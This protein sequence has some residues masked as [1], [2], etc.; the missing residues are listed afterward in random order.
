M[1]SDYLACEEGFTQTWDTVGAGVKFP[2]Q[3]ELRREERF[4]PAMKLSVS[5]AGNNAREKIRIF[6]SSFNETLAKAIHL[7]PRTKD[8]LGNTEHPRSRDSRRAA[9]VA[10]N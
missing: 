9:F 5:Y 3:R 1:V 2:R 4:A 8:R 6:K 7:G 10:A